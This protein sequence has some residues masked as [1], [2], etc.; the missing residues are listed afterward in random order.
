M[1]QAKTQFDAERQNEV[2]VPLQA[3]QRIGSVLLDAGKITLD[4]AERVFR[5]QKEQ[6]LRFGEAAVKLG[7]VSEEDVTQV[8]ALQFEYPYLRPGQGDFSAEL[9]AAYSPFGAEVEGLR[10]LRSQLM[11]RWF[12][13]RRGALAIVAPEA[14]TGC[15]YLAANLA[16]VF[17]QLGE[18]T[19]LVDADLRASRQHQVFGLKGRQGL[20][21]VL[22]GRADL[23]VVERV[24]HFVDLSVLGAGTAAPNPQEL[25]NRP[26]FSDAVRRL[27]EAYEVI[28][29]DSSPAATNA[30]AQIVAAKAGGALL[31]VRKDRT[32]L[33]A[34]RRLKAQ[35]NDAGVEVVGT[36][37]N[38]Y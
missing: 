13:A 30:D 35:L 1:T 4:D 28:L 27:G 18:R 22:A 5:L 38:R 9:A 20:S 33:A 11:L 3:E 21:D 32:R 29:L 37:L 25:L 19:V 14:G 8:L 17:S 24:P 36:V 23:S 16:V 10:A 2:V 34:V 7:L 26:A 15:S 31:V 6:N 12:G